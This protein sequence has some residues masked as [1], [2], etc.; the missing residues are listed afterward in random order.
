LVSG[1]AAAF[2]ISLLIVVFLIIVQDSGLLTEGTSWSAV[3]E[4]SKITQGE[5]FV[6]STAVKN[7]G[8]GLMTKYMLPL[9]ISGFLLLA[10]MV[11]VI[12]L[13]KKDEREVS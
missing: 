13:S 3:P 9:Q 5:N 7:F 4:S 8:Y 1:L 10:A 2:S 11:G 12:V 6:F